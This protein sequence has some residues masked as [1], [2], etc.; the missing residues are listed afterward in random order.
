LIVLLTLCS[1]LLDASTL[2][3][4]FGGG[5]GG[6]HASGGKGR[7][8][9]SSDSS[10]HNHTPPAPAILTPHCGRYITT[11]SNYYEVVFMP[12]QTRI[13]VFDKAMKP[14]SAR[15]VHVQMIVQ[16]PRE[17]APRR[18]PLQYMIL[19]PGVADQ[20]CVVAAFDVTRLG[21]TET[22]IAFQFSN[23]P[24]PRHPTASYSPMF[25]P[26]KIR[27]YVAEVS[28]I[29][30]DRNGIA[31]QRVCAVS[32]DVL[33]SRGPVVKLLIGDYPLYVCCA[34]C[35]AAVRQSPDRF[36]PQPPAVPS[37]TGPVPGGPM[38]NGPVP[39]V[40]NGPVPNVS[41]SN[42]QAPLGPATLA[43]GSAGPAA[44]GQVPLS[45]PNAPGPAQTGPAP[46]APMPPMYGR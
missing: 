10:Q 19:P 37:P 18:I 31:R 2:F 42:G 22:P 11:E 12:M 26:S 17:P 44:T 4:Q 39:A 40:P 20:D 25:S 35:I 8:S 33:G 15:E 38:P 13:Y 7:R 43:P 16:L 6:R 29:E 14:M 46:M 32:G 1:M 24:D 28:L 9:E 5:M 21:E 27:P 34:E 23:L 45:G 41:V 30:P 36:L 3:G